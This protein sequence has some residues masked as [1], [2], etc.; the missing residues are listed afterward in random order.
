M[1]Q[2]PH[3]LRYV[4]FWPLSSVSSVSGNG[5]RPSACSALSLDFKMLPISIKF[6][7]LP[8]GY[9]TRLH[10]ELILREAAQPC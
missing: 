7:R 3:P 5:I 8:H 4:H 2:F 9:A 6:I 1:P 10:Y